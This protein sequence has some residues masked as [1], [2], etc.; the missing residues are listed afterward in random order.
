MQTPF[1]TPM[2]MVRLICNAFDTGRSIKKDLDNKALDKYASLPEAMAYFRKSEI[3]DDLL[4]ML[5]SDEACENLIGQIEQ[6]LKSYLKFMT[7]FDAN[8]LNRDQIMPLL[9]R[10]FSGQLVT[11]DLKVISTHYRVSVLDEETGL[12]S[13][14]LPSL[15]THLK[16]ESLDWQAMSQHVDK[17]QKD[18]LLSWQK[19]E[20]L[21]DLSSLKIIL[22]ESG[23]KQ[24]RVSVCLARA[25]DYLFREFGQDP[26]DPA[27]WSPRA[28]DRDINEMN[29]A[30]DTSSYFK[31]MIPDAGLIQQFFREKNVS[32]E[33]LEQAIHS[34][35]TTMTEC[36]NPDFS[37]WYCDWMLARVRARQEQFEECLE[38]NKQA[39][40]KSLYRSMDQLRGVLDQAM[41]AAAAIGP[42]RVFCKQIRKLQITFGLALPFQD[43]NYDSSKYSDHIQDWEVDRYAEEFHRVYKP[44]NLK[45]PKTHSGP[46]CMSGGEIRYDYRNPDKKIKLKLD[47]GYKQMPQLAYAV[48]QSHQSEFD[49]LLAEGASVNCLTSSND[50]P[51][52]LA[53]ERMVYDRIPPVSAI[54]DHYFRKLV[55]HDHDVEILNA[56]TSKKRLSVMD[57]AVRTCNPEIVTKVLSQNPDID[58]IAT[59][60]LCTPLYQTLGLIKQSTRSV[61]PT[62]YSADSVTPEVLEAIRRETNGVLGSDLNAYRTFYKDPLM[63]ECRKVISP[64][65][66]GSANPILNKDKLIQIAIQL[67]EAGANVNAEHTRPIKGYTPLMLAVEFGLTDVVKVMLAA[68][69]DPKKTYYAHELNRNFDSFGVAEN[70]GQHEVLRLLKRF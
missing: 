33:G 64:L 60:D 28:L 2:E 6:S 18:M 42:D 1:F 37:D 19:G 24:E 7:G 13:T 46:L 68:G 31:K 66:F 22:S 26:V 5:G 53:L 69:G 54:N 45:P 3:Y 67:I 61:Y 51:L 21:P 10:L 16:N 59:H 9:Y 58:H 65:I 38:L 55:E 47:S 43:K 11:G 56:V 17:T 32:L 27:E 23:M 62:R 36:G 52:L 40:D 15:I 70:W 30:V 12:A 25:W 49:Q 57:A 44:T 34:L 29:T 8:G 41:T 4:W 20:H 48:W 14:A 50:S 35:R 39:V 63:L